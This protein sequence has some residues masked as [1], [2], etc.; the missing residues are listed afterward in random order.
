MRPAPR[1]P[2]DH[3]RRCGPAVGEG[4]SD[5]ALDALA[6]TAALIFDVPI[7]M[8]LV[9]AGGQAQVRGRHGRCPGHSPWAGASICAA[10][11]ADSV[12][13]IEDLRQGG[14]SSDTS[15]FFAGAALQSPDGLPFGTL[16]VLGPRPRQASARERRALELL[17]QQA[18]AFVWQ[19]EPES[20]RLKQ[21]LRLTSGRLLALVH[22]IGAGVLVEDA[23]G[24]IV[25][26]NQQFGD[27]FGIPGP[28]DDLIGLSCAAASAQAKDAFRDPEAF[29]RRIA[30]LLEG[31]A[32]VTDEE[33]GLADGRVLCRDYA[34]IHLDGRLE[35]HLW[36][37]RDVTP[38]KRAE[39]RLLTIAQA[40]SGRTGEAFL[41]DLVGHLAGAVGADFVLVGE[42]D[43][44]DPGTVKV[45][46]ARGEVLEGVT[47]QLADTP[48]AN[49]VG[50]D[51][52]T[53]PA[54]VQRLFPKDRFL[55]DF[56]I[57]GY[58]GC[59]LFDA[60]GRPIGLI[61][62]LYTQP[63]ED[64]QAIESTLRIFA[65]RAASELE[66]MHERAR[67]LEAQRAAEAGNRA[68]SEFLATM[69]HELRTPLTGILGFTELLQDGALDDEQRQHVATIERSGEA[70]LH[71]ID[72]L[73]DVSR[74]EA[75][76][77]VVADELFEP[78]PLIEQAVGMGRSLAAPKGLEVGFELELEPRVR[79]HGD[80]GR[81]R[82]VSRTW[83][84][85]RSS[86]RRRAR[87][88]SASGS[89]ATC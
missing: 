43:P 14:R 33:L 38:R 56:D 16:C 60:A 86:S 80:R 59:P 18:S 79:V 51:V 54:G 29:G 36:F 21:D 84:A 73:L 71:I 58:A 28:A 5:P 53:Y 52:C 17:A 69:S 26:V 8:V 65:S 72:D 67:T 6:E 34:P 57:E 30:Q 41:Q 77:L 42:I 23:Q 75:D 24:R 7:G 89:R 66:R 49:V 88:P 2:A 19:R 61:A 27:L 37:Y 47:Y 11:A 25:L 78:V 63:L 83:S 31:C 12:A 70:L 45:I 81:F 39:A 46:A 74:I 62:T 13:L 40:V 50:A 55:V 22:S 3:G 15:G 76:Q 20:S 68:K 85:T 64:P 48:C 10:L 32:P 35:G 9:S 4:A 82:Q 44:S 87:S 1:D